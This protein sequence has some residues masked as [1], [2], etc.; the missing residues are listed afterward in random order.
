MYRCTG[1]VQV[2]SLYRVYIGISKFVCSVQMKEVPGFRQ[3]DLF[4]EDVM[5]LDSF[6]EVFVWLGS[7]V[8]EAERKEAYAA[9]LVS[10]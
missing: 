6:Q 3:E 9:G 2:P 8:P 5:I 7:A 1:Y 4:M 10:D